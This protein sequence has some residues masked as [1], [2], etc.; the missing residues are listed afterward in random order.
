VSDPERHYNINKLNVF[1]AVVAVLL[2]ITIALMFKTDYD[3]EWRKYQKDFLSLEIQKTRVDYDLASNKLMNEDDYKKLTEEMAVAKKVYEQKCSDMKGPSD[4]VKRLKT[5]ED[6]YEQRY[7][8]RKAKLD[9]A[10]FEVESAESKG[11]DSTAVVKKYQAI[12]QE[13][14][15]LNN[16]I[17]GIKD[18]LKKNQDIIEECG[19]K[20]HD[21][22]R[23]KKQL[24]TKARLLERK[25]KTIDPS[26]MDFTN[27]VANIVRDLPILDFSNPK[28]KIKQIILKGL[29]IY[30]N[31]VNTVRVDRCTTCHLGIDNPA[32]TDAPQPFTTHPNLK[33]YL[34]KN[35][36][37]PMDKFG[38][39]ICHNGRG[40]GTGFTSS[41]H[42][43]ADEDQAEEW[44]QNHDWHEFERWEKPMYPM[45]YIQAG[46]FKCHS[47]RTE[48]KG[49]EKLNTGLML[50]ERAGCYACHEVP[51]HEDWPK[52]G[53]TLENIASKVS[54][55]WA[56][57]WIQDPHKF[58]YNTWMPSFFNQ[59]NSSDP[60]SVRWSKQE[61]H[62]IVEYLFKNSTP[63]ELKD[64]PVKGDVSRG[65][66]LV[67]SIGCFGCHKMRHQ[68]NGEKLTRESL[69]REQGP[70]L[71]GLGTKTSRKWL[72]NW[73]KDPNR[74]H[75]TTRMPN[76]RLSD[77]E[78][79]DIV[80]FLAQDKEPG[81]VKDPIPPVNEKTLDDI[82]LEYLEQ[83]MTKEDAHAELKKMSVEEKLLWTG[84]KLIGHY[85]CYSC[86]DIKGFKDYKPIGTSLAEIGEKSVERLDFGFVDIPENR[87][88]WIVQK[89]TDPRIFDEGR[90]RLQREKLRMP[91]FNFS[92]DEIQAI[93]TALLGFV[94]ERPSLAEPDAT[95]NVYLHKGEKLIRQFN[96][97]GCHTLHG[98]GG[99]I[100][101]KVAEWLVD[102]QGRG[103]DEAHALIASFSPPDLSGEGDRVQSQWL[104]NFIH[105]P[106]T[107]RPWLK[108]RMPTFTTFEAEQLNTLVKYFATLDN[109]SFPFDEPTD[110]K[111]S[112]AEYEAG[113]KLFSKD[114]FACGQCH[115]VGDKMPGGS[116][117]NWAPNF[118][119]ARDRL[120]H[121]WIVKFVK[122]PQAIL[123]GA[124]M[125]TFFDPH[126][127]N[128]SGPD[129]VLDGDED[130]QIKALRDYIL[131]LAAPRDE[132]TS[133]PAAAPQNDAAPQPAQ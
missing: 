97:E 58:R 123:P 120:R 42:V 77:Q 90:I 22:E 106:I 84:K 119:L 111:I 40:R 66:E 91:N 130:K 2:L 13:V 38:C 14:D 131:T 26:A 43:P 76:L 33:L 9:A 64:V 95:K 21:L 100:R 133:P 62:A 73:L 12:N 4:A 124:K 31:F 80:E 121:D 105:Q 82:M 78:A 70:N 7:R 83:N 107:I 114:Y 20:F 74:Y 93:T 86:H 29:P 88:A 48:I 41:A 115:I 27:D 5:E 113:K 126:N 32:Y 16:K 11:A 112:D 23:Q 24:A 50:I 44:A 55:D 28:F 39:T 25:L 3:R 99:A 72:Y 103:K 122:N 51:N 10:K 59:T 37:H 71:I 129:D 104:F 61:I 63:Y 53:P 52:P 47:K 6:V 79:A 87:T 118:A 127:Y 96:C 69:L 109:V 110:M 128:A 56:Y 102:Y 108:V 75:P 89:L 57:R 125:P 35:S 45:P 67:A 30:N 1:F 85:G 68:S 94:K 60:E 54:K 18:D 15:D 101:D 116:P 8:V 36:P 117:E 92:D 98:E 49:A 34:D 46:C 17:L 19:K 81:F 132:K 65:K